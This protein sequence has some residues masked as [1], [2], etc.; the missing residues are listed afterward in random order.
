MKKGFALEGV[1]AT[2]AIASTILRLDG[3]T[4]VTIQHTI[5]TPST[6][7]ASCFLHLPFCT[8]ISTLYTR[9]TI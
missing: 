6:L 7:S 3:H 8:F 2:A 9:A 4:I 5:T 1:L